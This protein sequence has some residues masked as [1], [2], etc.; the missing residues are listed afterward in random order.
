VDDSDVLITS[1]KSVL[2]MSGAIAI[3]VKYHDSPAETGRTCRA[4]V[5][6]LWLVHKYDKE[7]VARV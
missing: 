4:F 2:V 3:E 5:R 1:S 7:C 6:N